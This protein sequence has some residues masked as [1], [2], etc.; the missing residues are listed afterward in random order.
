[1]SKSLALLPRY[2]YPRWVASAFCGTGATHRMEE[3]AA[4][5]MVATALDQIERPKI[6]EMAKEEFD[7]RMGQHLETPLIPSGL[8][9]SVDLR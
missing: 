3:T 7:R 5:M 6:F 8:S 1:V 9:P 2:K 4:K